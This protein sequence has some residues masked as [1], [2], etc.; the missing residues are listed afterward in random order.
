MF[1]AALIVENPLSFIMLEMKIL[2]LLTISLLLKY[3]S[4]FIS[5]MAPVGWKMDCVADLR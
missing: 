5:Y 4:L 3:L 1:S 2:F